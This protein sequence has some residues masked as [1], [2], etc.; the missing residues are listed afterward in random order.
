VWP[1]FE[2]DMRAYRLFSGNLFSGSSYGVTLAGTTT[3]GIAGKVM[4][5]AEAKSAAVGKGAGWA[6]MERGSL[7]A[8]G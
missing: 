7:G 2:S 8:V 4:R 3:I 1:V 6:A 5:A